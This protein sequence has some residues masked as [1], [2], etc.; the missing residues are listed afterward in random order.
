ML[1]PPLRFKLATI[2]LIAACSNSSKPTPEGDNRPSTTPDSGSL[3][4]VDSGSTSTA[5]DT[6]PPEE[7]PFPSTVVVIVLD[8]ARFQLFD[9]QTM[10]LLW[11]RID[12]G[13]YVEVQANVAAWTLPATAAL[14]TGWR[15]EE[16]GIDPNDAELP[17][18][19]AFGLPAILQEAGWATWLFTANPVL[20]A[21]L[22]EGFDQLVDDQGLGLAEQAAEV[23][24]QL[25]AAPAGAKHFVWV[26]A[27]NLHI[28][29]DR[30]D[31]SC[32]AEAEL[33]DEGCPRDI[34]HTAGDGSFIPGEFEGLSESET[35]ACAAAIEAAQRCTA[36]RTDAELDSLIK[37]LP[38][39]AMVVVT[40][41]HGEGWLD[42]KVE[43][44][45]GATPKLTRGFLLITHPSVAGQRVALG[46]QVDLAPT[47]LDLLGESRP[48]LAFEGEL[49]GASRAEPPT[50]WYCGG[51]GHS[52]IAAWS[53]DY[54]L[55]RTSDPEFGVNWTLTDVRAD[56]A[57]D[58]D[59]FGTV[60]PPTAL[61]T[62][63]EEKAARNASLCSAP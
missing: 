50:S 13:L 20:H 30:L 40:A 2:A 19:A 29:Y 60:S 39:K 4:K 26:Q 56:P 54:Q 5:T 38:P 59:L 44:N 58:V 6:G 61:V 57:G 62:A 35:Q 28:P 43:H 1:H 25:A 8:T 27:M 15:L 34:I 11:Q 9:P 18:E 14:M 37:A 53:E 22:R 63:V 12:T 49:L 47:L 23:L 42:P 48:D 55:T 45:W 16:R 7:D 21:H 33:A 10:P 3:T 31:P 36:T 24:D 32:E 46:S 52:E 41:D 17:T 51:T